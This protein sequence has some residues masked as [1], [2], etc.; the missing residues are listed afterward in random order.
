MEVAVKRFSVGV[1]AL[2]E[3]KSIYRARYCFYREGAGVEVTTLGTRDKLSVEMP[4]LAP[5]RD[6]RFRDD[7]GRKSGPGTEIE[8]Y[9][10]NESTAG[11]EGCNCS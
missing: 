7:R 8:L 9:N 6:G 5:A 3:S 2:D 10:G 1:D 11:A 4:G